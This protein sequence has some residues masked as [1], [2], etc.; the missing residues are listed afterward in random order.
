MVDR[1]G[2]PPDDGRP[3]AEK[4]NSPDD[5][6]DVTPTADGN[7]RVKDRQREEKTIR[8]RFVPNRATTTV[9][10]P[11]VIHLHW[12]KAI[13]DEFG[14]SV[15]IL[16]NH[17]RIVP[18]IDLLRW[19]D[20][21]HQQ[22]FSVHQAP[23][24]HSSTQ[25][26]HDQSSG[27]LGRYH[28]PSDGKACFIIHRIR[29]SVPLKT[30]KAIPRITQLLKEN[31]CYANQH[32]WP[33]DVWNTTQIGFMAGLDPQFYTAEQATLKVS[34]TIQNAFPKA[35]VPPFRL[36]Y[37][38]PQLR[39]NEYF[40]STKA[41]A[42][43][44]EKT[45]GVIL[46]DLLKKVYR[47]TQD[48]IP[49]RMKTKNPKAFINVLKYQS[50][51]IASN[52]TIVLQNIG[53][54]AMYYLSDYIRSVDGVLDLMPARTVDTNGNYRVLV[55]KDNFRPVRRVLMQQIPEWFELHVAPDA[56]PRDGAFP[57]DPGVASIADDG[58]SSGDDSY[59]NLSINT[60]L[61][62]DGSLLSDNDSYSRGGPL[63]HP[64]HHLQDIPQKVQAGT[65]SRPWASH[66]FS[67]QAG[68]IDLTSIDGSSHPK[69]SPPSSEITSELASS[70][71]E[72]EDM[73][74]QIVQL[75]RAFEQE[76][77]ELQQNFATEKQELIDAMK[78]EVA[79]IVRE[80]MQSLMQPSQQAAIAPPLVSVQPPTP[81]ITDQ[82][83]ALME[84]QDQRY[85]ALTALVASLK[86][87]SAPS[88]AAKR[89]SDQL[90]SESSD[91]PTK[92]PSEKRQNSHSTPQKQLFLP[93]DSGVTASSPSQ[94]SG[95]EE[96]D[97]TDDSLTKEGTSARSSKFEDSDHH[98][99]KHD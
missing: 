76:K 87:S 90:V 62:Y 16:D 86:M 58:Y 66:L 75:T 39:T 78:V 57:G 69:F 6:S 31:A 59:M 29:T 54:D 13:Q 10:S 35:K 41:Y 72:V 8:F 18:K 56:R 67:H 71:A 12:I 73:R 83:Q 38:S 70:R 21:Q 52:Y 45:N 46:S 11:R 95:H 82:I 97:L 25:N 49:F 68:A 40:I 96:M 48:F 22:H 15:Q 55:H 32:K 24:K 36:T 51:T 89:S 30:M 85:N 88:T 14:E 37:C 61:S 19:T 94:G 63:S 50:T 77:M 17:N 80:Q 91:S 44:T 20:T 79:N 26:P 65:Q 47:E 43:E 92:A 93:V 2:R 1:F 98:H 42:I 84:R 5:A 28:S 4:D 64:T 7:S 27:Y 9:V 23:P 81:S 34:Q 53:T 33:E 74:H 3:V 99:H 60:A